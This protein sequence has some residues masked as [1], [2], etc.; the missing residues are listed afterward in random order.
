MAIGNINVPGM[1]KYDL[2]DSQ[3]I[4]ILPADSYIN[5]IE[6][7]EIY[8]API[9][10]LR[11]WFKIK[12]T[13]DSG[14]E[15]GKYSVKQL[16]STSDDSF[17]D[18]PSN[19]VA[20]FVV[21]KPNT[22][23]IITLVDWKGI[24]YHAYVTTGDT[25][26]VYEV[27]VK[28]SFIYGVTWDGTAATAW[29]RTD[30]SAEFTDP[31]PYVEGASSYGSP[32]DD[33]MPWCGMVKSTR[34]NYKNVMV[35]IP[36]FWYKLTQSGASIS[37]QISNVQ[38]DGFSVSPAHMDRG[39]GKERSTVY[40]GRYHSDVGGRSWSSSLPDKNRT[41]DGCRYNVNDYFGDKYHLVDFA[42]RFTIWLLYLVEF[43]DWDS[44]KKIGMGCGDGTGISNTGYTD[45]MPYH[46]GTTQTS[47]DSYGFGTQYRNI[48]GLWDNVNDWCDGCTEKD[49][50]LRV[51]IDP[52]NYTKS[53]L[54]D[55]PIVCHIPGGIPSAF[56]VVTDGYFPMFV[57]TAGEG[58]PTTYASDEWYAG[59]YVFVGGDYR[60]YYQ[61]G[62]FCVN[63][64]D[65]MKSNIIGYR[66]QELP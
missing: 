13:F 2:I 39:D 5:V 12:I 23:Y 60:K 6:E 49:G 56:S 16:A 42:M 48:E 25:D 20:E 47:R 22:D 61:S 28:T 8:K 24:E 51:A 7:D 26:G 44:Q 63:G 27:E 32:F 29:S 15:G 21:Y 31:V 4:G 17:L 45:S 54:A 46:T 18:V 55:E 30:D 11:D 59:T 43:A 52:N 64:L 41:I 58:S 40:V 14:A 3:E 50:D 37:I 57:P 65:S 62:L 19:L 9:S 38:R 10:T 36:K 53:G 66:I 34:G 33:R 35:E 1:D